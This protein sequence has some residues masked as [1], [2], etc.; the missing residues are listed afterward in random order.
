MSRTGRPPRS[1]VFCYQIRESE[2]HLKGKLRLYNL[3]KSLGYA[4]FKEVPSQEH[5]ENGEIKNFIFDRSKATL[6]MN[7]SENFRLLLEQNQLFGKKDNNNLI[8]SF[9]HETFNFPL[10]RHLW[11]N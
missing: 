5:L 2:K 7:V 9:Y 6:K 8:A 1:S 11:P 3:F 4:V 10:Y